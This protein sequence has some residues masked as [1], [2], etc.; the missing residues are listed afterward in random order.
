MRP[1]GPQAQKPLVLRGHRLVSMRPSK[2]EELEK[3]IDLHSIFGYDEAIEGAIVNTTASNAGDISTVA[4][5]AVEEIVVDINVAEGCDKTSDTA[6][7]SGKM[8]DA[9]ILWPAEAEPW[10]E[11]CPK[12][13]TLE[14]WQ[15]MTG[16]WRCMK[17]DP[18]LKAIKALKR[19]ER[20]RRRDKLKNPPGMAEYLG[21][22]NTQG[23]D[24]APS[25]V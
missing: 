12:C 9:T 8:I 15:T 16:R 22:K 13:G 19:V 24:T 3:V 18:P 20:T 2:I 11:P 10:P 14:L 4:A 6:G 21:I 17:C 5:E 25:I 23:I 1:E 7:S